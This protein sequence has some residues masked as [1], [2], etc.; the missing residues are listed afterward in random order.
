MIAPDA[1][2]IPAAGT[3]RSNRL[4]NAPRTLNAPECCSI[5]SLNVTGEGASP[6]SARSTFRTGVRRT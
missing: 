4:A 5:S 3:L 2:A 1:A 6:K